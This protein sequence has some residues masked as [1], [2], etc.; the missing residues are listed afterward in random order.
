MEYI[1]VRVYHDKVLYLPFPMQRWSQPRQ[2]YHEDN[3]KHGSGI[4]QILRR[5]ILANPE[6]DKYVKNIS[7]KSKRE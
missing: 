6:S 4:F 7:S 5:P 3:P 1:A 2:S